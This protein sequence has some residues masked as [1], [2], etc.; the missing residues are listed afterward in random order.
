MNNDFWHCEGWYLQHL[1]LL[2]VQIIS[3]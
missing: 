1:S 3:S 2:K